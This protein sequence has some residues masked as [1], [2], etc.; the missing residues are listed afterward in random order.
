MYI[1]FAFV[2][3]RWQIYTPAQHLVQIGD[4]SFN[5]VKNDLQIENVGMCGSHTVSKKR[6]KSN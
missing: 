2:I 3:Q 1:L 5:Q 4:R 6:V